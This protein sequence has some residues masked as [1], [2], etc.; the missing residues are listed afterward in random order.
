MLEDGAREIE[1][2]E[3][4]EI[5][6]STFHLPFLPNDDLAK[7]KVG[8]T[9]LDIFF[10]FGEAGEK[11]ITIPEG[12]IL[13]LSGKKSDEPLAVE[14]SADPEF[15]QV[16]GLSIILKDHLK[17]RCNKNGITGIRKGDAR[18]ELSG[19]AET[20]VSIRTM[21]NPEKVFVK[22]GRIVLAT[23]EKGSP[24]EQEGN[25]LPMKFDDWMIVETTD[26][27]FEVPLPSI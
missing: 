19:S 11:T 24:L 22:E 20:E 15:E 26:G 4:R 8:P 21:R 18:L 5:L 12:T 10:D 9:S 2:E 17:I 25:Y 7:I 16:G 14:G 13:T 27:K 23:D 1:G 3:A 6:A